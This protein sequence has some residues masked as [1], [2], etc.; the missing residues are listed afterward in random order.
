MSENQF[1]LYEYFHLINTH[2]F[3]RKFCNLKK[4]LSDLFYFQQFTIAIKNNIV[5][6]IKLQGVNTLNC[7][8][9]YENCA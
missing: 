1:V 2:E 3:L 6:K 4:N 5:P 7:K 9:F 8:L